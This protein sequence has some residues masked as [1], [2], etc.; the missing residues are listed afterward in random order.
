MVSK[1]KVNLPADFSETNYTT[2]MR[3]LPLFLL[4]LLLAGPLWSQIEDLTEDE[5]YFLQQ[6]AEYERWLVQTGLAQYL[7]VQDLSVSRDRVHLYL[8]VNA[9]DAAGAADI[10]AQLKEHHEATPGPTFEEALHFRLCNL[11]SL[12][13]QAT[14]IEV[15]DTYDLSREPLFFR[16]IYFS[17][18]RVQVKENNP[19]GDKNRYIHIRSTEVKTGSQAGTASVGKAYTKAEV[20]DTILAFARQRYTESPCRHRKPAVHPK[21]YEDYLRFDVSDLCREVIKEAENPTI[22][23]WLR[24]LRYD[25]D[26]TARE[27]LTFTFVYLP[28]SDGF[29]IH[30]TLEGRVGSGYYDTVKRSG[31]MDMENDFKQELEDYTDGIVFE[32]RK[33][34]K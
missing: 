18:G 1:K 29:T 26:W 30:L 3:H 20:F 9:P 33:L 7:H 11:M 12:R 27:L 10:W 19:K 5:A 15:Y 8:G 17:E 32:I 6:K 23:A 28:T 22:C 21:P 34:F 2:A 14:V 25:C 31:Y 16:G 4:A 24:R 13:Q